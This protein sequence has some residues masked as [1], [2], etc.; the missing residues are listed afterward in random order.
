MSVATLKSR[1][2]FQRASRTLQAPEQLEA[3]LLA[4]VVGK[5]V[6]AVAEEVSVVAVRLQLEEVAAEP[7]RVGADIEEV[8]RV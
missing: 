2:W 6:T 3:R 1:A 8:G 5:A 7:E 4:R